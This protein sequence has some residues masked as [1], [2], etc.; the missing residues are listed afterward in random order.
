MRR[1]DRGTLPFFPR[2]SCS[3][4]KACQSFSTEKK[5]IEQRAIMPTH[6][7]VHLAVKCSLSPVAIHPMD[8]L[9]AVHSICPSPRVRL[10]TVTI[11]VRLQ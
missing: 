5:R 2:A 9:V 8:R 7:G 3:P 4:R 6:H 1:N 10:V 11:M